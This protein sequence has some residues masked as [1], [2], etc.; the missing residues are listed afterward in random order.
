LKPEYG[1]DMIIGGHS[2][3]IL[4]R[5]EKINNILIAQLEWGQIN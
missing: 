4:D 2:H 3:T 5:P 1:V